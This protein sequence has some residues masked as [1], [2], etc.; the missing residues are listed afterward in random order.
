MLQ[1][2][3]CVFLFLT[4]LALSVA[5]VPLMDGPRSPQASAWKIEV[6]DDF[7]KAGWGNSMAL[8]SHDNPHIAYYT[9]KKKTMA[10]SM[11]IERDLDGAS[12]RLTAADTSPGAPQLPLMTVSIHT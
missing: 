1:W 12:R 2:T 9:E 11:L 6:V 8:D 10:S 7:E 3:K 5:A 4:V